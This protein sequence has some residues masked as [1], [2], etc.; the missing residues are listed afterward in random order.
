[1]TRDDILKEII[2][3]PGTNWLLELATGTGKSKMALEKAKSLKCNSLLLVVHRIVHKQNWKDEIIKWWPNC[4]VNITVT[5]YKSLHK[6]AGNYDCA[7]FDE[8]HHLSALC[9][10]QLSEYTIKN[11]ILCSATVKDSLKKEFNVLFKDLVVYTKG[12]RAVIKEE[13]LPD[14]K[15]YLLPL[16]LKNDLFTESIYK[17]KS[18][19]GKL[20]ECNYTNR[21]NH[22]LQ[23]KYPV[24]I[25]CTERQYLSDLNS[26]IE[27][28]KKR[29]MATRKEMF[30]NKW[31]KLCTDRLK[32]LSDKK[33][34]TILEIL[35]YLK[36]YRTLT[37][38]NSI[39]QTE[40]LGC[41]CI[42]SKNKNSIRE[43]NLFNSGKIKHITACNM[44]NEGMNLLNCQFGIYANL[45]SSETIVKQRMGRLLRHPNPILIIP[46]FINTREEE[47]INTMKEDY[48]PNL[49]HVIHNIKEIKI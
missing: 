7:I 35:L 14:P 37:F 39:E 25:R 40:L 43:L 45:N 44:L 48:N 20:V 23:T 21:W 6:Y 30:K 5:T 28:W 46:Y 34:R 13:I 29:Y 18:A 12:L 4:K 41:H 33:L 19:K 9:R 17:N 22:I 1:M 49:I 42:N 38:C 31:L 27:Y 10:Q 47:L 3:L 36:N 26:Q 11:S 8:C 32:W 16:E 15:I 24:I 2:S